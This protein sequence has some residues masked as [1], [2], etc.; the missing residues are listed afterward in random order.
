MIN[1]IVAFSI[2]N[3]LIV[4]LFTLVLIGYGIFQFTKL[5]I[6]AV[7]DITDNQVQVITSAPSLGATDIERLITFPIEQVN[8]N[9]PGLKEIRS[10]SRFGLSVVTIVFNDATDVYWARQQVTERLNAVKD[11][12]PTG[13]GSPKLA[14]VTT[15]LGEIYQ[16][17]VR[18]KPGYEKKYDVT[19]LR[20]IQDWIVRRQLLSVEGVAEVSSFGGKLKQYEIA[21]DPNKLHSYNITVADVFTALEKN[22]QNTGGAYIEKGP[23][24]LYI[25]SEGLIN[26]IENIKDISIKN[27]NSGS[28]LF[29]RDVAEVRIG[30]AIRYGAMTYNKRGAPSEEVSGAVVMML[31]GANSNIVIKDIKERIE[32]I[33]KTLPEGV[34]VEPFIDRTKMVNNSISTVGK[35]LIEGALIV[36]LVLIF[37]LGNVRAGLIVA[38][39]IPLAMLF[40][41]ILMNLFGVSGNLMSLG[42]LD[43]GLIV[44]GAV[45]IVEACL[46]SLHSRKQGA[47]SQ[48]EMDKTVLE[49]SVR[50]RNVAVFG[51][52]IILIVYIPIFTL[53]GIEG[54]MFLPM[55]QTI[56]FALFGA[57]VLSLTYIPMMTALFLNKKITHKQNFSDKMMLKLENFYQP[58][59]E[60]TLA[61]PRKII[62]TTL[63]LFV[64]AMVTLSFMGGEFMPSLEEGDFAV[65]TRVLPGS[66]LQTSMNAISQ[67]A[68]ILLEKFPEVKK[69]VGKTGSSEV[70]T[71]PMPIDASD[72]MIILK[73]KSEWTSASTFD[74]LAAEM[75]KE[76]EAVPGVSYGFQY[77]VQMRFNELMTGA[78]QDVVCKIF[79]ENLD[80]LALYANKLG[81]I[82]NT[83]EGTSDLY[84]ETVTGMPQI[85]IDYN[86][87][88][89]AQY[90]L[91]IEDINKIVNTAFAGQS[92][93]LIYEGEKRFDLVVRLAG[94][95]RKDLT[96][97]QNLLIPTPNGMQIP[98]SQ[99][100]N[101]AITE[102]PNQIQR[103]DAKRRIIVGFNVRGRDVQSIVSELQNKV[104]SQI[105]FPAGYYPTYGGAFENLNAAKQR[106]MIA[107][108]ISL[109]LIFILL[110]FA[111]KSV[112]Q[113]LLI[114]SAIP[115]SM[116]GGIFFLAMRGMPF[117]I[118]AG[119]GFIALFGVAVLN[120]LVLIAEFNRIKK[121][122]ETDLKAIVL[123]GTRIR[124]RPV[125]MTALVASLGFLPMALSNGSGA[126]VQRPLATVVIGGLLIAT[127]LT[128][129]VLP[130]LYIMFEKGIKLKS[131]KLKSI[132]TI[133]VLGM[134]FSF[135]NG[136][137]QEKIS[138]DKAI[139]T[140]L[141]NNLT[142]KNQKLNSDYLQKMTK[143]GYDIS[144]TGITSEYGQLNGFVNDI[145][146]GISQSIKFP[147]IYSRQKQLLIE[148]AKTGEWNEALQRKEL[149]KQVTIVFYEMVY[150]QEKEK[151]LLKS[152]RIYSEFLRKSILRF[153]KGESNILEKATAENQSGQIKIQLQEL[154]SDYK[155]R[156]MQFNYLLN[157][158]KYFMPVWD[159]FKITFDEKL[160]ENTV[161]NLP[162][163]KLKEQEV[164]I[165]KAEIALEKSKKM[166]ELIGGVY[167]Q[168]F[169]TNTSFQENYNGVY[170]Q[171]GV[172]FP[173]FNTA[174]NNKRKAL[175]IDTQIAE[176]NLS[177][178]KLKIKSRY[179]EL[180]QQ[181]KK[182]KETINYY[183]IKALKN[184]DLVTNAA[185]DKFING[186]I[187]YLEWVMLI[188]QS[189]EI[190]SNY[191]E[192]VRKGNE[193]I[194]NLMTLTSK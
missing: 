67:G 119:V 11:E 95:K 131:R 103:E 85:V 31:K 104:N 68:K 1:K 16:Y 151:L 179:H 56:A 156:Q 155:I 142:V 43:F 42:A 125:L 135:Q 30:S 153:D 91:N 37:F 40:A 86:R 93:G 154:Q 72:M 99:L 20:T 165:N 75:A 132:S 170:G 9:I 55:A 183:E 44:D 24:V 193:I 49:T 38:S 186:D 14:P 71:D 22:N 133:I 138:I 57:F 149:T 15:G 88:A 112:K 107:V 29:I 189:T 139:E 113:G 46:F 158:D 161:V 163:I 92:A 120:G 173:L 69:V 129:F 90:N 47:I 35:N 102:G 33:S 160:D 34:I 168:T 141:L 123:E 191:I 187:N 109:I 178:E 60:K 175:E 73:D 157:D 126:E 28:P 188:N 121:S 159:K 140:A 50:M 114:Y 98:L 52:L 122:G 110:F 180:L 64:L 8:S 80:T 76:L 184:V 116:I 13:I 48:I 128:L 150:L 54:K 164:N 94:E 144:N 3:K 51:E 176:N 190:Q 18:P 65:E 152:D 96:D 118:S 2:K 41:V 21:I 25:R 145:K 192:A 147:T 146:I 53:R 74:E 105:K 10:F 136:N 172:S 134:F 101:V 127:F 77:P 19:E 63:V 39:V 194:I 84:V 182:N 17:V 61:I 78:R 166:P 174:L 137:A 89:I 62:G 115:L 185:N 12:I 36:L 45:I 106:L 167:W 108:P 87:P 162:S 81:R 59:L 143:T 97:V 7:P 148:E 111:F 117:S 58:L 171:F 6:D 181:Y 82:V 23:T 66:N 100:A 70:P 27:F 26:T 79:G 83:V 169:K 130:I 4:G 177:Y 32:Q 124:L 5:P